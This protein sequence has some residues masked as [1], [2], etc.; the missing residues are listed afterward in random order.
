[1]AV[2]GTL[3]KVTP[4]SSSYSVCKRPGEVLV[5]LVGHDVELVDRFVE[6][7][8]PVLVHRQPQA[9]ADL[10]P[11]LHGTAGLVQRAN[12]EDV[13]VVPAFA[14]GGMAEDEPQRLLFGQQP[15]LLL[16]DQVVDFVV[17]LGV[18]ARVLEHALLVLGE[19][20]VVQP[21]HRQLQPFQRLRSALSLANSARAA[22]KASAN[23]PFTGC[24]DSS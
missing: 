1:M 13:R 22:S 6:H 24:P 17:G 20:A 7:P 10:L 14:Q 4:Q 5:A 18:A 19:V 9:A 16:H 21:V 12:L 3:P 11:L 15:L 8:L 2:I 23:L